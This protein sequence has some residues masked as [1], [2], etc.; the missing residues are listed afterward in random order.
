VQI[1]VLGSETEIP[2]NKYGSRI[3]VM[4]KIRMR[5]S[6]KTMNILPYTTDFEYVTLEKKSIVV[7]QNIVGSWISSD[8]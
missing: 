5:T 1:S 4:W 7:R 2:S 6:E 8:K 3:E